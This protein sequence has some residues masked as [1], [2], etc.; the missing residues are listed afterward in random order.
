MNKFWLLLVIAAM[1]AVSA[2]ARYVRKLKEPDFFIPENQ[3]MHRPEK[4]PK[5][6]VIKPQPEVKKEVLKQIPD[7]KTK[8]NS[9]LADMAVFAHSKMLPENQKVEADLAAMD[10][11]DVF[12]VT[13]EAPQ[14][15]TAQ[16]QKEF[17]LLVEKILK[18]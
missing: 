1:A 13:A 12:E 5:I 3:R 10:S 11:G 7:Y 14:K 2:D 15:L 16:E 9:Y 8:Y 6:V 17:Y 18:N 4:L